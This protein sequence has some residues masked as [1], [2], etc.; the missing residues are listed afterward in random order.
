MTQLEDYCSAGD[1]DVADAGKI[2]IVDDSPVEIKMLSEFLSP[3]FDLLFATNGPDALVSAVTGQPVM[4]LLDLRMPDMNGIDVLRTLRE[5]PRSRDIPVI[6]VTA[7]DSEA[8]EAKGIDLGADDYV[9]KPFSSSV[10]LARMRNILRRRAAEAAL[11]ERTRHLSE[12]LAFNK[13]ILLHSPLA[14]GVYAADG[15]CILANESYAKLVGAT[16]EDLLRQNFNDIIAWRKSGLLDDCRA[17]LVQHSPRQREITTISSFGKEVW[18]EY[19]ILPTHLNGN[20]HLLIQFVDLTDRKRMEEELRYIAFHDSLTR[21]PN[22]RLLLDRLERALRASKRQNSHIAVLFIDLN[23]FKQLNDSY[24]HD[25]G[26]LMLIEVARRLLRTVRD[27]DTAARFGGDE[28]VVLLERMGAS[29]EQA[30]AATH[31]V[32]DKIRQTLGEEYVLGDIRHEG[33][34]SIGVKLFLGDDGDP[35][36]ILKEADIAMYEEKKNGIP[37]ASTENRSPIG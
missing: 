18:F 14:I 4:I 23:K 8:T 17:A 3:H 29:P 36:Q 31:S 1:V 33:S 6:I 32:V 28:F 30:A 11:E 21:L 16:R 20:K 12:A 7:D 27:S 13:T 9:T 35:D 34:V 2:L 25:V 26:D 15:Q 10:L 24:G 22:R 37:A 19:Q 5:D